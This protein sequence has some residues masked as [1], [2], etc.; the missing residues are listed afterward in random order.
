MD[1]Y[2]YTAADTSDDETTMRRARLQVTPPS[3]ATNAVHRAVQTTDELG[4]AVLLSGGIDPTDPTELF[5]IA[6]EASAVESTLADREAI[7]DFDVTT[8]EQSLTYVYVREREQNAAG[9]QFQQ[10]FT[11]GTLVATLPIRF[12]PDGAVEFTVVGASEDLRSA[13]ETAGE[14]AEVT[15]LSVGEGWDGDAGQ[16]LTGRQREVVR[17]ASELGYYENPRG[18]TQE[19]VAKELGVASST[20]AEHLRKAESKLVDDELGTSEE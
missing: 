6:G 7:R 8:V 13:V 1:G 15:V 16:K 2:L 19:E 11:A 14:L 17:V 4:E 20:V 12:R 5:T 9:Q 3:E 18:A 10:A